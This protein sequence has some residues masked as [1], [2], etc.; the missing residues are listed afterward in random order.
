MNR[1]YKKTSTFKSSYRDSSKNKP[2][3]IFIDSSKKV[4]TFKDEKKQALDNNIEIKKEKEK[5]K[6][7][8]SLEEQKQKRDK[9]IH[10]NNLKVIDI[11][12]KEFDKIEE[13]NKLIFGELERLKEQEKELLKTYEDTRIDI[14]TEKDELEELK[15]INDEKNREYLNLVHLRH[16]YIMDNT[17][18]Q[19]EDSNGNNNNN[20]S[21]E[22]P[23][24]LNRFTLGDVMDGLLNIARIRRENEDGEMIESPFFVIQNN[25]DGPP[26]SYS[27][28]QALPSSNYPR[29]NN[30]NE[31][32][33]I[34]E[35]V[36][37]Y[38]DVVTKLTKCSHIFHKSCL[39]NRLNARQSS[40][41]PTCKISII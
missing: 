6:E 38:N 28:I 23:H 13:E 20:A 27:Q 40:K 9:I 22:R 15:E 24:P 32:C 19:I 4:S 18:N 37:C 2:T 3:K 14:E 35:F 10:E 25:E 34:C 8:L 29:N 36:F 7:E 31:K 41:C 1:N 33:T 16:R 21:H 5:E 30:N 39:V 12:Q 17:N 11:L 26:M